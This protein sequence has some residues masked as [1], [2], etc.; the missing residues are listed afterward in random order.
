MNIGFKNLWQEKTRF[1]ISV[2]GV[3]TA[4]VLILLLDALFVGLEE[5]VTAYI[6]ES[7]ADVWVMQK[8]VSNMHMANTSIPQGLQGKIVKVKGVKKIASILYISGFVKTDKKEKKILSYIVGFGPQEFT[9]GPWKMARGRQKLKKGEIII[10]EIAAQKNNLSLGDKVEL[11]GKNFKIGGFSQETYS[12]ANTVTFLNRQDLAELLMTPGTRS[13]FLLSVQG[14]PKEVAE[15]IKKEIPGVNALTLEEF[16]E[17]DRRMIRQMGIDIINAMAVIGFFIGM[18]VVGLTIYTATLERSRD[19]GILKAIGASRWRLYRV[20][21]EQSFL[22]VTLGF[23]GGIFLSFLAKFL[24]ENLFPEIS[25]IFS[26]EGILNTL[27]AL[28]VI[29]FLASYIPIRRIA[30]VDPMMVFKS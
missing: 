19:F 17:S 25:L 2:A 13:Y 7:K 29:A 20:V 30:R 14:K 1:L 16:V 18:L 4:L 23:F 27:T 11:L 15:R 9:G 3:G 5:K 21:F 22:S 8:G 28:V 10:D 12:F 6:K 26:L 24:I